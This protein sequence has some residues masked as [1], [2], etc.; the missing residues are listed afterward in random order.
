MKIG[1]KNHIMNEIKLELKA[2]Q[3]Q[4][5]FEVKNKK[6]NPQCKKLN[7]E[8]EETAMHNVKVEIQKL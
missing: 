8:I 2:Q 3:Q 6:L 1:E 4:K 5:K 7:L